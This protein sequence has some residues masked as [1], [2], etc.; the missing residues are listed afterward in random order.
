M[1]KQ[2]F[3][4]SFGKSNTLWLLYE[5][6]CFAT[7]CGQLGQGGL[8]GILS[9]GEKYLA[10][11]T[12]SLSALSLFVNL[13]NS[14]ESLVSVLAAAT[15]ALLC[16]AID[17]RQSDIH[18]MPAFSK[19][20]FLA[21]TDWVVFFSRTLQ[22]YKIK[23][24]NTCISTSNIFTRSNPRFHKWI[25]NHLCT[26]GEA[27]ADAYIGVDSNCGTHLPGEILLSKQGGRGWIGD[28]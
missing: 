15:L 12:K 28:R 11:H 5:I 24:T 14:E 9:I 19:I 6:S 22:R 1:Y 3:F 20:A 21:R 13:G 8:S 7:L 2:Y 10:S 18:T 17:P 25:F 16:F 27:D 23:Y 4:I 26:K